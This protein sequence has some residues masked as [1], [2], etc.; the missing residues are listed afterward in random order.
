MNY[1]VQDARVII[2][3]LNKWYKE[4]NNILLKVWLKKR[5]NKIKMDR[6]IK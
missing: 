6:G 5:V 2:R 4:T 3:Y 1:T